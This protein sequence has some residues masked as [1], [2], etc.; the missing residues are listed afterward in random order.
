ML[1]GGTMRGSFPDKEAELKKTITTAL[2]GAEGIIV[3]DNV[4]GTI[5]S[6][7][8]EALLTSETWSDRLLGGNVDATLPNDRLWLI[9]GNNA[10]FGGDMARR[11]LKIRLDAGPA[12]EKRTGFQVAN[13][14]DWMA[15]HRGE[16]LSALMTVIRSWLFAGARMPEATSSDS[17]ALWR[18][19]VSGIL[20]H[21]GLGEEFDAAS[22]QV[23][24]SEEDEEW[25][26]FLY[27]IREKFG[28]RAWSSKELADALAWDKDM[29]AAMPSALAH[30]W[31]G[32]AS[33][34]FKTSLSKFLDIRNRRWFDGVM[35][36]KSEKASRGA[37]LWTIETLGR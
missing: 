37:Y 14:V 16:Y 18:Q 26:T 8:L 2:L 36:W 34:S 31:T 9:T 30:R 4:K 6:P 28:T 19:M 35:V 13:P 24:L 11:V 3:F 15:K 12:P 33:A 17:Y 23:T 25:E 21:A 27:A 22:T 5:R 29:E 7:A 20:Q 10:S 32:M 1:H